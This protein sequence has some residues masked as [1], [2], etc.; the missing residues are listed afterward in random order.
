[1]KAITLWQPWATLVAIGKK[2]LE[3]R[4][5]STKHRGQLA[6]HSA[7][8][9]L[10]ETAD[11]HPMLFT[12]NNDL[13]IDYWPLGMVLAIVD[14]V[15]VK[16]ITPV[17]NNFVSIVEFHMGNFNTEFEPRFMWVLK[18]PKPLTT[19]IPEIGHQR[20]WNWDERKLMI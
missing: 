14:L 20:I 18:N 19:T 4:N 15:D 7:Q 6:I 17:N 12:D 3:T 8:K 1:M 16:P 2:K 13:P 9:P 11:M 5:W 10:Y